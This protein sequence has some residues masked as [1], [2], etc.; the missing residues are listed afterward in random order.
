[1]AI[2]RYTN[3]LLIRDTQAR[4]RAHYATYDLPVDL[5][6]HAD[7]DWIQ[8]QPFDQHTWQFGDRLDKLANRFYG[9]DEYWWVIAMA[10]GISYPLGIQ[11]GTVIKIP[12]NVEA[13]LQLLN[14]R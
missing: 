5:K 12:A 10:N 6:G 9:D 13:V 1:M 3:T 8:N 7:V 4:E 2:S 11:P 14:L